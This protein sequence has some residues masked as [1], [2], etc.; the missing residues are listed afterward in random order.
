M[1][2][3]EWMSELSED[4]KVK[5]NITQIAI[6]GS[7]DCGTYSLKKSLPVGPDEA[8]ILQSL[9]N[10]PILGPTLVKPIMYRWST[11]QHSNI[12]DQLSRGIRYFDLRV[13]K[14]ESTPKRGVEYRLL[15]GLYGVELFT[16]LDDM[17]SFL[18]QHV[19]EIIILD[20]QHMFSCL[21]QDHQTIIERIKT[22]FGSKLLEQSKEIPTLKEM[23]DAKKQVIVIY[24][25]YSNDYDY[26]WPRSFC[27]SPWGNTFDLSMLLKFLMNGLTTVRPINRLYVT[28]AV[29]TP[30]V[31]TIVF[32]PFSTLFKQT[33]NVREALPSWLQDE[34]AKYKPNIVMADFVTDYDI[35][36]VILS[37]NQ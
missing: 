3:S 30:Q 25:L 1:D 14:L 23:Q 32:K 22:T 24:G 31:K 17:K 26:L 9:G 11:T 18:D 37:L 21:D 16:V 33:K 8:D 28:Q 27:L 36:S 12:T 5:K 19:N 35:S 29:L 13:G 7:H 34:A 20:F 6:P 15:H 10:N 4:I 2:L